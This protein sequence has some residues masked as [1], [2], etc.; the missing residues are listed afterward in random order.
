MSTMEARKVV[1]R[2]ILEE[3]FR[4]L[5]SEDPEKAL[6]GYDL[7][8]EEQDA[9][10]SIPSEFVDDV[11]NTL[12]ERISMSIFGDLLGWTP[13]NQDAEAFM[14]LQL[15]AGQHAGKT[16]E[17]DSAWKSILLRVLGFRVRSLEYNPPLLD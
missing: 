3:D 7:N 4:K 16:F 12:P 5:L 13:G 1:G 10:R 2:A 17:F 8:Q 15:A 6:A 9:L 11:A 14:N